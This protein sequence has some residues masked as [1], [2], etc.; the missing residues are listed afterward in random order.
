MIGKKLTIMVIGAHPDDIELSM[1]GTLIK[2]RE[3]GHNLYM[4]IATDG[5]R[6]GIPAGNELVERRRKEAQAAAAH[7][8]VEPVFLDFE[9]GRLIYDRTSYEKVIGV[10]NQVKPDIVFTHDPNDYHEDHRTISKLVTDTSWVP[11]FFSDTCVGFDP[12]YYVDITNQFELKKKMVME[13]VSQIYGSPEFSI[14]TSIEIQNSFRGMQ[15]WNKEIKYAEAFRLC[16]LL[17]WVNAYE[18]LPS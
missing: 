1:G 17:G 9:D 4:V 12:Q 3:Q 8:G 6:G 7:I 5:R 2:Y 10:Y 18:L 16:P 11:V 15:C 13:H 14:I